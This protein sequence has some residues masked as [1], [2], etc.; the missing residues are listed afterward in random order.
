VQEAWRDYN[1][2]AAIFGM[3]ARAGQE[4]TRIDVRRDST[5]ARR[6]NAEFADSDCGFQFLFRDLPDR[7]SCGLV[8]TIRSIVV[9]DSSDDWRMSCRQR[10]F[11][12]IS[13]E[14]EIGFT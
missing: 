4:Y 1:P 13:P 8:S 10:A 12:N 5:S 3:F 7:S 14:G 11:G 6:N 9:K 2:D